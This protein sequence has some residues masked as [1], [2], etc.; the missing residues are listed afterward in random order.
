MT[1]AQ[2]AE[3]SMDIDVKLQ[4]SLLMVLPVLKSVVMGT[5][6]LKVLNAM[7]ET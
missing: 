3:S 4:I 5:T 7:M 6:M 2:T 1:V